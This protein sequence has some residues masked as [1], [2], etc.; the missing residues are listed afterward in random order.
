[1]AIKDD[2]LSFSMTDCHI[3]IQTRR[4]GSFSVLRSYRH[5]SGQASVPAQSRQ[6]LIGTDTEKV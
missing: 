4:N 6:G 2:S 3:Y 1:M 5:Q